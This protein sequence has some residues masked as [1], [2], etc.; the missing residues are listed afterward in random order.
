MSQ[1]FDRLRRKIAYAIW[2]VASLAYPYAQFEYDDEDER[3]WEI[4]ATLWATEQGAQDAFERMS[5]ATCGVAHHHLDPCPGP[6]VVMGM[7]PAGGPRVESGHEESFG[8]SV[9]VGEAS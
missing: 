5:D 7:H 3:Q 6:Q 4:T 8:T 1:V 2:A 9:E